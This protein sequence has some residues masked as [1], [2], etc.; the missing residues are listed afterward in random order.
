MRF[1]GL[2]EL[3]KADIGEDEKLKILASQYT[4]R[5]KE[6]KL[7]LDSTRILGDTSLSLE[8][9]IRRVLRDIPDAFQCPDIC[10]ASFEYTTVQEKT[11]KF[12]K[13]AWSLSVEMMASDGHPCVLEIVYLEEMPPMDE[14]PF[15]KEERALIDALGDIFLAAVNR[16]IL[17]HD[18]NQQAHES[19]LMQRKAEFIIQNAPVPIFEINQELSIVKTNS[20][21]SQVTGIPTEKLLKMNLSELTVT[22]R[23]GRTAR[24][25]IDMK[26]VLSGELELDVPAGQKVLEYLYLPILDDNGDVLSV[27]NFYVD[28]TAEKTAVRDII[29]LTHAAK[30]GQLDTRVDPDKYEGDL[31]LLAKG[32]NDT[33]D[34]VIG[35][36]NV[37]AEYVDRISKGDI[38]PKITD[39]YN[40]DFNEIKNNLNQCI[41]S[42]SLLVDDASLLSVAAVE[43]KL[44]TR[45]DATKHLGAFRKIVEGVNA[46]LDAVIGPLNVAAEYVDRISK[47]DIPP[48]ITDS[49]SGDF[50]EIKNNLNQCIEAVNLLIS[51]AGLLAN[52]AVEGKLDT[53]ADATKHQG[54]FREIVEGVNGTLD[55][56]IGPL[57][58]AAEYV[59]RISKGDIPPKITDSYNGD[60]NEIKNNL[61]QCIEAVNLL[62]SDAGLLAS[63]AVEGKLDTR[64]DATK[65]HGDFREIVEGV[66]ATLD[67]VIG[68]LNVA[69]EYV[70]R[71][72]K[73]DIPPKITDSYNG[74]FNEIKNNLNQCIEAVNL[75]ISDAGLLAS[76]AVEGKLDTRAD[77]TKHQG[78]FREIVEGVNGTLDAVIGPLNVAA[79]YVDRISKGDI[80]PKITDSYNGDFNEIKNN[81]NQCI[82]AVNLLI[83]DSNLLA[84]E[85]VGGHLD[86]R[87]DATKH[88][89]DFRT[90][91]EGVNNTLDAVIGPL[92][93]A[94]EYVDRISKGDIPPKITDSY[95]GDFN[96]IKNN[97]NQCIDIMNGLLE[98]T[99]NLIDATKSGQL[100]ARGNAKN[101]PG[102]WGTLVGG[103][104]DLIDAFVNPINVTA[105]YVDRI[106]KGDIPP[107]ITDSYNGDFN[108]IKN[109]LNQCIDAV[110][111]L[112]ADAGMLSRAAVEGK[113]DTRAD[114]TKHQG[115]FRTIVEGVNNTLDAVIG[116]LNVA[117][118]YVDR[119]S[120]G[121]IPPKITD[122]YNG[123]FN[124]I[125][126]NLN[127][128]IE[129]VNL[130][131][132]DARFLAQAAVDGK[133]DTRA[134]ATKHLGD[135]RKIV[136]GVNGTLDAVIGPVKEAMRVAERYAKA[137]FSTRVDE[138][139]RVA[140]DFV[141]FKN[142]LNN[143][144]IFVQ[145]A[146][147][148]IQRISNLYAA[149]NFAA[150]FDRNLKIE[151]DLALL[152]DALDKIGMNV[153]DVLSVIAREMNQL[154]HQAETA[155]TGIGD[156]SK[157]AELIA[158]NADQTKQNAERSEDGINQVLQTMEDLTRTISEVSA[159]A[160]RV[161][162]LSVQANG[163]AKQGIGAAGKADKGMMSITKT[164][165]EVET[166]F[167]EIR[168]Q[169]HEIV[170]IVD[171]ITD[172][173]NQ[174]NLLSLN[175]A[176]EAARAGEAGK[177]F[178]VV[179]AEV[180]SL[181]QRSRQSAEHIADMISDLQK[182]SDAASGAMAEAGTAVAEGSAALSETL[183]IFN[184]LTTSV[185]DITRNMEMVASATEE[186]A[187]S[188]EEITASVNEMSLLVKDTSKD[189]LNS[190]A[191]SEEALAVVD[192]ITS[193][194][195]QINEV[196]GTIGTE[197][198]KFSY[199]GKN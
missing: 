125:K 20:A 46:T 149:G 50:N 43:G 148:E 26:T 52:A 12:K 97:L 91:V 197:M 172:I 160:E 29:N 34:A 162:G 103:V 179:A 104:N 93:V 25:A 19:R 118:E 98:E 89:G 99:G 45:A 126:N 169:M 120:K 87:A 37:A 67:A 60:F 48:K 142:S 124:E 55:A 58:V 141:L 2:E 66:N 13:T 4:E 136:E 199:K 147:Q 161:A 21:Y 51:D 166:I 9:A 5:L 101:F 82:E 127:Q 132:S 71:I 40:G 168:A 111:F 49:Y 173:A 53:R 134:D 139:L 112:I 105:E 88:Q 33:L 94:A 145:S 175:A 123:D 83:S 144:G 69:A 184:T 129:A 56:V 185:E 30:A 194:I 1:T 130:L 158:K 156:V 14:G 27:I 138:Q 100:D 116:P 85:A 42:V 76:A 190:S 187:A 108:E 151:G 95:N 110:S 24:E 35:P 171:L 44:D 115:D 143:I 70:D 165:E 140:G 117:A 57:N 102:G 119:I 96:E 152:R 135:F 3:L 7:L 186:Q 72:S 107:K 114:A 153:S 17:M 157:G 80:P 73:G 64:A 191:T 23:T 63:A 86:T 182:K 10:E 170:K 121:D 196:V 188:F 61:N 180:K 65:H 92:N 193:V 59:D 195:G 77:A 181:A 28:K 167:A 32:I 84:S 198:E 178:A 47:G 90:I 36:L 41:D 113:L 18:V 150:E 146:I 128:C 8:D 174:T 54:D 159:N 39:S 177:G 189:A 106:S 15:L 68:P 62:I 38:P 131:V 74:D 79:E 122:S 6:Q 137:D 81:L 183:G 192:Q 75:L 31:L 22:K 154:A 155:G 176:I 163:L 78:D 16:A 109:N 133:L 11:G 164:S